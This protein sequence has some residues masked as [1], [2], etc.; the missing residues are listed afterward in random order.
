MSSSINRKSGRL[1][2]LHR[3]R[4][5]RRHIYCLVVCFGLIH[6]HCEL[7]SESWNTHSVCIFISISSSGSVMVSISAPLNYTHS[8]RHMV[9]DGAVMILAWIVDEGHAAMV[10][11]A[12]SDTP[13]PMRVCVSVYVYGC[14]CVWAYFVLWSSSEGTCVIPTF[15]LNLWF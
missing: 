12:V 8:H 1:D 6:S 5:T 14:A 4:P 2:L 13:F 11:A 3:S 7:P 15:F 10:T 9:I